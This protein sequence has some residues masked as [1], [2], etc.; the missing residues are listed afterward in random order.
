ME[1]IIILGIITNKKNPKKFSEYSSSQFHIENWSERMEHNK[2]PGNCRLYKFLC[3]PL[4]NRL[5]EKWKSFELP[6]FTFP[7]WLQITGKGNQEE[8]VNWEVIKLRRKVLHSVFCYPELYFVCFPH[9]HWIIN[10]IYRHYSDFSCQIQWST[11]R[12]ND[13]S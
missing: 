4:R 1:N 2:L 10:A 13:E 7:S 5:V 8:K 12:W 9:Y 11:G 3:F 6:T